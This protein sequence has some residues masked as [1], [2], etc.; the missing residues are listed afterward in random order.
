MVD[1]LRQILSAAVLEERGLGTATESWRVVGVPKRQSPDG[2]SQGFRPIAV[3]S[4]LLRACDK[5]L[6]AAMPVRDPRQ[7]ARSGTSAMLATAEWLA[8]GCTAGAEVDLAK[9]FDTI[10]HEVAVAALQHQG[11]DRRVTGFIRRSVWGAPRVC[12]V[13]TEFA[14]PVVATR[15]IPAGCPSCP[16]V[17]AAV[18]RP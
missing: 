18:L 9:A 5:V 15:G 4:V 10:D 1:S 2:A 17:L 12:Q 11:V 3:G 13:A 16:A 8:S 14:E 7:R 6:T